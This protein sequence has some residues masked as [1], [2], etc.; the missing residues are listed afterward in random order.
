MSKLFERI[1]A[2]QSE[3]NSMPSFEEVSSLTELID[4]YSEMEAGVKKAEEEIK[5]KKKEL[6][7]YKRDVIPSMMSAMGCAS[8]ALEDGTAVTVKDVLYARLPKD[9]QA[10]GVKWLDDHG[11]SAIVKTSIVIELDRTDQKT[12]DRIV[13]GLDKLKL[14]YEEALSIHWA[15]LQNAL[16]ERIEEEKRMEMTG[17]PVENADKVPRD[18]FGVFEGQEAVIKKPK[19]SKMDLL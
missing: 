10:K 9:K 12:F 18:L 5:E 8:L 13:K 15:T 3:G 7:R 4:R 6:D 2:D 1:E 16:A 19:A 11:L 17:K 14:D